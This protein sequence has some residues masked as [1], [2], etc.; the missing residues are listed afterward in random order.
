MV[1]PARIER[2]SFFYAAGNTPA[3]CLTEHL[4][5]DQDATLLLLGCGD[6]RNVIFTAY[7]G[8]GF[9]KGCGRFPLTSTQQKLISMLR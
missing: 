4:P 9:G 6:A 1:R 2:L 8:A 7:A 3:V 5:P